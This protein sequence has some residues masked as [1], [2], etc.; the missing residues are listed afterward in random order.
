L[1]LLTAVAVA[2]AIGFAGARSAAAAHVEPTFV[3]GNPTCATLAPG[4]IEF[5]VEPVVDGVYSDGNLSVTIDVRDTANGQ[6]FDWTSNIGVDVVFA[7]GGSGGNKYAYSPEAT[8]DTGLHAPVNPSNGTYFGL[9]HI[10]FCYDLELVVDKT[11][12]PTWARDWTWDIE[13]TVDDEEVGPFAEGQV[14]GGLV[15]YSVT[16][17]A[18]KIDTIALSGT[19][20]ISNPF[21]MAATI[22]SITDVLT[23]PGAVTL[24]GDCAG[25]VF[26]YVLA[27]STTLNCTWT[28]STPTG[29]E[30]LNTVTVA[31]SGA[32]AGGSDSAAIAYTINE[33]D[34][35]ITL[36]DTMFP[37]ELPD[38]L[39]ASD[40]VN[41]EKVFTYSY[42]YAGAE[43]G[44]HTNTASFE[45]D[46][47]G[48]TGSDSA[49]VTVLCADNGC[50]LTP[51]YWKT[52]ADPTRKQFDE[53]WIAFAGASGAN[54]TFDAGLSYL[55]VLNT[56]PQGN[57]YY[58][59]AHAYIAALLNIEAGADTTTAVDAALTSAA[60]FFAA[61]D[62]T[63]TLTKAERNA[64]IANAKILDDYNNGL[65]GPGHCD[66]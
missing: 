55:T 52:H 7:K 31:T 16:L 30:T 45:T 3:D 54:A 50:T 1:V 47:N 66:E 58:I 5:K 15:N 65:T 34:E 19:I 18:T 42:E 11:A 43:C 29:L 8:A 26:P 25:L 20:T 39:C 17:S 59:L 51:G 24:G 41:G 64:A 13:K 9:S 21:T 46:D 27:A 44:D 2:M 22:T 48:E 63:S 6:V 40:L 49:T 38:T 60:A 37:G 62:P 4:T 35:C 57:A 32:I 56:A 23:P 36:D 33:T 61:K 14:D 53:T 28:A 12:N 10:T